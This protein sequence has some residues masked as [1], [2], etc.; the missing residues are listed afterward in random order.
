MSKKLEARVSQ[1]EATIIRAM[2]TLP[3]GE[4]LHVASIIFEQNAEIV[5]LRKL[6]KREKAPLLKREKAP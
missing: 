6:L 3:P 4:R 1:L 2:T 5:R